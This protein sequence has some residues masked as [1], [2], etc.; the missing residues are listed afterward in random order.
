MWSFLAVVAIDSVIAF[1][2]ILIFAKLSDWAKTKE[3]QARHKQILD[4]AK[5][6][7]GN[8]VNVCVAEGCYGEACI[9][10]LKVKL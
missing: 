1:I 4:W 2:L 5:P 7:R 6:C 9:K 3:A 8:N 10:D